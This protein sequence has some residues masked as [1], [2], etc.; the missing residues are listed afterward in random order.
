LG[1]RELRLA[2]ILTAIILLVEVV[3]GLVSNSLA[4]LSDAGH[5]VT[6]VFALGLAWFASAQATRPADER[7]TFGY[8]R[9]GILAAFANALLLI[10]VAGF[11][12]FEA[13]GRLA[14]PEPL[15]PVAMFV[16]AG[17]GIALNLFIGIRLHKADAHSLNIRGAV[18]HVI[19]DI[20][21]SVG[22]VVAG[23]VIL[24]TGKT[25]VDPI[26]SVGIALLIAVGAFRLVR[27][28]TGILMEGTPRGVS[29]ASVVRDLCTV[30]GIDDVH[31]L[32]IWSI[33]SGVRALSCHAVI[34]DLPPSG[35]APILDRVSQM[36]TQKYHIE[37]TTIQFESTAHKNHEGHCA[38]KGN[39]L[40][41]NQC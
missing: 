21:A 37:H 39:A 12:V 5:A 32:H 31:D 40:Y 10:L 6:D 28:A 18:L 16:S 11:I 38:C 4:L 3:G 25:I 33:S 7:N 24:L 13:S 19:G 26:L 35:S 14:H 1:A 15:Q 36:L 2:F 23:V 20:G 30:D 17:V 41:C 9:M 27:E 29:V 22:V 34:D 8:Q